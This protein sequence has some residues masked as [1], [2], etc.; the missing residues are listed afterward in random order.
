M[1]LRRRTSGIQLAFVEGLV[2]LETSRDGR[3]MA[4]DR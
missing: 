3:R 4:I 1:P 2:M